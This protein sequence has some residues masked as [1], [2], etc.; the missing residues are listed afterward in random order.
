MGKITYFIK[1]TIGNIDH[2]FAVEGN[3]LHDVVMAKRKLSFPNVYKCDVCGSQNLD[4]GAHV[5]DEDKF[6]Y[7]Y[8]RCLDC[9]A[10]L[11]FGQQKKDTDVFYL[12]TKDDGQGGKIYD[13]KPYEGV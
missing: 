3:S 4:L 1:K 5:T 10:T 11:N 12:R 9:K 2:S 13:W 7:T 6:E 8:I